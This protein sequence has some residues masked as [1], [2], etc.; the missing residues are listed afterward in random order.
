MKKISHKI[1]TTLITIVLLSSCARI[2]PKNHTLKDTL[3]DR[4]ISYIAEMKI[5]E[6][7]ALKYETH[8][9]IVTYNR[10]VL[11]VGQTPSIKLRQEAVNIVRHIPNVKLIYNRITIEAP[12]SMLTRSSDSWITAK[13]GTEFIATSH[14]K[15]AKLKIVTE[16]GVVYLMGLT[17]RPQARIAV[18][19]T[20]HIS[21]VLKVINLIQYT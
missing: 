16:S 6:N 11:L 9:S 5:A 10:I 4:N 8:I 1:L 2:T 18:N 3:K 20:R 19:V 13:V 14:L 21:G 15:S 12:S 7:K 17:S